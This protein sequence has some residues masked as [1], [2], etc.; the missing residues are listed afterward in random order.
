MKNTEI[1]ISDLE[2]ILHLLYYVIFL[3]L[4]PGCALPE[5]WD[6]EDPSNKDRPACCSLLR[7]SPKP[8]RKLF[9]NDQYVVLKV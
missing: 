4:R 5:V 9:S 8:F 7:H 6:I 1:C 3:L 2:V